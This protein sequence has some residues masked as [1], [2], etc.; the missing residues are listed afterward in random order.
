MLTLPKI[1]RRTWLALWAQDRRRS[2]VRAAQVAPLPVVPVLVEDSHGRT[3]AQVSWDPDLVLNCDC[4]YISRSSDGINFGSEVQRALSGFVYSVTGLTPNSTCYFRIRGWSAAAGYGSY[5]ETLSVTTAPLPDAENF[6]VVLN[7]YFVPD[8][9]TITLYGSIDQ[10]DGNFDG[11]FTSSGGVF[12][13]PRGATIQL[14]TGASCW[15]LYGP[16]NTN[17]QSDNFSLGGT[18]YGPSGI[19]F[20]G[21]PETAIPATVNTFTWIDNTGGAATFTNLAVEDDTSNWPT[22]WSGTG[23]TVSMPPLYGM[24][25]TW[26]LTSSG[27]EWGTVQTADGF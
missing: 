19:Y 14:N 16:N 26:H 15:M 27:G 20:T 6:A 1:N 21:Y 23:N 7:P 9:V 17:Y 22:S 5:S 3:T 12:Y 8:G 13:R 11:D 2:R 4:V 18:W 10:Q 24:H 25:I